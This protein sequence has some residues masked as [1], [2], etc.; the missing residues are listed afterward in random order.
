MVGREVAKGNPAQ[1]TRKQHVHAANCIKRFVGSDGKV[2]VVKLPSERLRYAPDNKIFCAD[3]AWSQQGE[4]M[5][6]SKH[7]ECSFFVQLDLAVKGEPIQDHNAVSEYFFLWEMR[8]RARAH[9]LP[10]LQLIGVS[11]S[12]LTSLAQQH[13][14]ARYYITV[15]Q[16]S[17]VGGQFLTTFKIQQGIDERML[18]NPHLKWGVVQS[19][20]GEFLVADGYSEAL[21]FPVHPKIALVANQPDCFADSDSVREMNRH[22]IREAQDYYFARDLSQCP[23]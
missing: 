4:T 6:M 11:G 5:L 18:A 1:L 13:M 17:H 23:M 2:E 10:D 3:R 9:P 12:S 8:R 16:N 21:F 22:S 7:I 20:S 14:E 19:S 15:D